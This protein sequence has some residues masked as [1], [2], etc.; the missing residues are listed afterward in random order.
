MKSLAPGF[1]T[2]N[3]TR[4]IKNDIP[5]ML[6]DQSGNVYGTNCSEQFMQDSLPAPFTCDLAFDTV[7]IRAKISDL[8]EVRPVFLAKQGMKV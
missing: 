5:V 1:V 7:D 2:N 8:F 3:S 4:D 6:D